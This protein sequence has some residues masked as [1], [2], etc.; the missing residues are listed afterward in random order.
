MTSRYYKNLGGDIAPAITSLKSEG[1][2]WLIANMN[3]MRYESLL[4]RVKT[5]TDCCLYPTVCERKSLLNKLLSE[6]TP[7]KDIKILHD[8]ASMIGVLL[9]HV[10]PTSKTMLKDFE[11]DPKPILSLLDAL[12][13]SS[14]R[15][16]LQIAFQA[17]T[18]LLNVIPKMVYY[19]PN[20]QQFCEHVFE[21]YFPLT[22]SYKRTQSKAAWSVLFLLIPIRHIQQERLDWVI[23]KLEDKNKMEFQGEALKFLQRFLKVEVA[24]IA[25]GEE[26]DKPIATLKH[27]ITRVYSHIARMTLFAKVGNAFTKTVGLRATMLALLARYEFMEGDHSLRNLKH[28]LSMCALSFIGACPGKT[29]RLLLRLC[30]SILQQVLTHHRQQGGASSAVFEEDE[31]DGGDPEDADNIDDEDEQLPDA[32][33]LASA[34]T[35]F[36]NCFVEAVLPYCLNLILNQKHPSQT[37]GIITSYLLHLDTKNIVLPQIL[38]RLSIASEVTSSK[39]SQNSKLLRSLTPAIIL[40][41]DESSRAWLFEKV[42]EAIHASKSGAMLQAGLQCASFLAVS[43][44][45]LEVI[46][47]GWFI[48]IYDRLIKLSESIE[49]SRVV[50]TG[51]FII[52]SMTFSDIQKCCEDISDTIKNGCQDSS[53][54]G[55]RLKTIAKF[56]L[57]LAERNPEWGCEMLN[58]LMKSIKETTSSRLLTW[59]AHIASQLISAV[60]RGTKSYPIELIREIILWSSET[61]LCEGR[62]MDSSKQVAELLKRSLQAICP[63]L[64]P[65][66]Y[67]KESDLEK[68]DELCVEMINKLAPTKNITSELLTTQRL[69]HDL[70]VLKG[71]RNIITRIRFSNSDSPVDKMLTVVP[72]SMK[73]KDLREDIQTA[74]QL[75]EIVD[76]RVQFIL[77]TSQPDSNHRSITDRDCYAVSKMVSSLFT[78]NLVRKRSNSW[79]SVMATLRAVCASH[80][81]GGLSSKAAYSIFAQGYFYKLQ[82]RFEMI[83]GRTP[84]EELLLSKLSIITCFNFERSRSNC[85]RLVSAYL[86]HQFTGELVVE[87]CLNVIEKETA[88]AEPCNHSLEG[89]LRVLKAPIVPI[90]W[91]K[92]ELLKKF[93][94]VTIEKFPTASKESV[95]SL[96][97]SVIQRVLSKRRREL[98]PD[99]VGT[100]IKEIVHNL[101]ISKRES[102]SISALYAIAS[103][104][105]NDEEDL[106]PDMT[107]KVLM[108][109]LISDTRSI[110]EL[111]VAALSPIMYRKRKIAS[112]EINI[113]LTASIVDS[114]VLLNRES[115]VSIQNSPFQRAGADD[116]VANSPKFKIQN[117][118]L[119]RGIFEVGQ[120]AALECVLRADVAGLLTDD[121]ATSVFELMGGLLR[122]TKYFKSEKAM[123][124][125]CTLLNAAASTSSTK[126]YAEMGA[127]LGFGITSCSGEQ[128][129]TIDRILISWV[130]SSRGLQLQTRIL[131]LLITYLTKLRKEKTSHVE[132]IKRL[133]TVFHNKKFRTEYDCIR[134][135]MGK[136]IS[137]VIEKVGTDEACSIETQKLFGVALSFEHSEEVI[138][139][140]ATTLISRDEMSAFIPH[141]PS[142]LQSI[143][144]SVSNKKDYT[145]DSELASI[146]GLLV[147]FLRAPQF[148][149]SVMQLAKEIPQD[150]VISKKGSHFIK[151]LLIMVSY[152]CYTELIKPSVFEAIKDV[153]LNRLSGGI[154]LDT[155]S[156][157]E[158][159][160]DVTS[161]YRALF[162]E[163][164][165][166]LFNFFIDLSKSDD[167]EKRKAAASGLSGIVLTHSEPTDH[168]W[169]AL[170][171]LVELTHDTVLRVRK[172]A[173]DS[174]FLW[175]QSMKESPVVWHFLSPT[176]EGK[177][178][179]APLEAAQSGASSQQFS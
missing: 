124:L 120:D 117:A 128:L 176:L 100:D 68:Y 159:A 42:L 46:P 75:I 134:S 171:V 66:Q 99:S 59:Y 31:S 65:G 3:T 93:I 127:G 41:G 168:T 54:K 61:L 45:D 116:N 21:T 9:R 162:P 101:T 104:V 29:D 177:S 53:T 132:S 7:N 153:L 126:I 50:S 106:I 178:L 94:D 4:A 109:H 11:I 151:S 98:P 73:L 122:S 92:T 52:R 30:R 72:I 164:K 161:V 165:P 82:R 39:V 1:Y 166:E 78:N 17:V 38:K 142:V 10:A 87:E 22:E 76:S 55:I 147:T 60:I 15:N 2:T 160:S 135:K 64:P 8:T 110:R 83:V 140:I 5:Y 123:E 167:P 136:I 74:D 172:R 107:M 89:I 33:P 145:R 14:D 90:V 154:F 155:E 80:Y 70:A 112:Q 157:R 119:W 13:F 121:T 170:R 35:E 27:H 146:T 58:D 88:K 26:S 103:I 96:Q 16:P 12:L 47:E 173:S 28:L 141:V 175:R 138:A 131:R 20:P 44:D 69:E 77:S 114:W 6:A 49:A 79:Y 19:F 156:S 63:G 129:I 144:N 118:Q 51:T 139:D 125:V 85:T 37:A 102:K 149:P 34:L 97:L 32:P 174:L 18:S 48:K 152:H 56:V 91:Q 105:S 148:I 113:G 95:K 108:E 86:S 111:T 43:S 115:E 158:A 81:A 163:M 143:I 23:D 62:E 133:L 150:R 40:K 25:S 137:I 36:R 57:C 24:A 71:M 179:I 169:E 84:L 67:S 130:E